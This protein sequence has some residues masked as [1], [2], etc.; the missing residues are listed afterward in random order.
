MPPSRRFTGRTCIAM[1]VYDREYYREE[2]GNFSFAGLSL[3][4]KLIAINIVLYLV[5]LIS[6]S[7]LF[8]Q[9]ALW[10][11][12]W[13]RPW[14]AWRLLTYGFTHDP[15]QV[16]H[17]IF[18]MAGLYWF[19][20]ELEQH[21]GVKEFLRFYLTA[22][23][24][25]G[26]AWL[27]RENIGAAAGRSEQ[28][29]LGA[30]GAVLALVVLYAMHYPYRQILLMGVLPLPAWLLAGLFVFID[31][32]GA[33]GDNAGAN[34]A[35]VAH[36][37]GAAFGFLYYRLQWNLGRLAPA[38]FDFKRLFKGRPKL[39]LHHPTADDENLSAKVD[40]ILDKISRQGEASLTKA[41]RKTL[42]AASRKYQ[43]RRQ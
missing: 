37:G 21:Y 9:M 43:Q 29:L 10:S 13:Q 15:R 2:Q 12:E 40:A 14:M 39:R 35:Y 26:V 11:R 7:W 23:V 16:W 41:E 19:G 25:A 32:A 31:L 33:L 22:I 34:V 38:A 8:D 28:A 6:G 17:V 3:V 30:S 18:N 4:G 20:R 24:V 27:V 5:N 1:G 36:L 42:E